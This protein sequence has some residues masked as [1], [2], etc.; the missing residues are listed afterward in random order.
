[1]GSW[2]TF[3]EEPGKLATLESKVLSYNIS[4][5]LSHGCMI[6]DKLRVAVHC[7]TESPTK[8]GFC[9]SPTAPRFS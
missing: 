6:L 2:V 1:M 7:L 5:F 3:P 8:M 9:F 4:V